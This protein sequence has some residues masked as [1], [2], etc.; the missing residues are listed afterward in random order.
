MSFNHE[1]ETHIFELGDKVYY[2]DKINPDLSGVYSVVRNNLQDLILIENEEGHQVPLHPSNVETIAQRMKSE[3]QE[4]GIE[5][6][7]NLFRNYFTEV[8]YQSF[9]D[10]EDWYENTCLGGQ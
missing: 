7:Y 4:R 2:E 5:G 3:I 6:L 1:T 8:E 9:E 10:F